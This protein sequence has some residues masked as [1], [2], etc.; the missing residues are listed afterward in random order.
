[1]LKKQVRKLSEKQ[2]PLRRAVVLTKMKYKRAPWDVENVL[3]FNLGDSNT[4]ICRGEK[5]SVILQFRI[6]SVSCLNL[7]FFSGKN[8]KF[9][10][11][12]YQ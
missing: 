1:M 8:S 6:Y 5:S 3:C 11:Y 7:K 4:G 9:F 2:L 10:I 12:S